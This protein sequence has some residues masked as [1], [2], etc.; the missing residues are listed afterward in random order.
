MER[1]VDSIDHSIVD[2]VDVYVVLHGLLRC[3][4]RA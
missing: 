1:V 3:P 4:R 2:I